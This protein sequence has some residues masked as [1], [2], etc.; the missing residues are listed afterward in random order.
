[1]ASETITPKEHKRQIALYAKERS[2]Y[3]TY[4]TALRRVLQDACSVSIPEAFAQS[5]AK[6][7]SSFAEKVV[8]KYHKYKDPVHELTDLC[9]ARV[10]VQTLEQVQAVREFV[11]ANF[12][13]GEAD[14]K[15]LAL[16]DD[17]FGYRDMHYIVRLNPKNASAIGFTREEIK[18]IG[19]RRAEIQVRTWLQHAWA[20]TLHDRIY[21]NPLKLSTEMKRTGNLLAALM[22]E[23]DRNYNAMAHEIDGMLANYTSFATRDDV[24]KEIEVQQLILSHEPVPAKRPALSLQ[25]GRLLA[26]CG[27]FETVAKVLAPHEKVSGANRCELLQD[28]GLALCK[29]HRNRPNSREYGRGRGLLEAAEALCRETGC[30][31]V[32]HLRKREGLHARALSRLA[33]ALEPLRSEWSAARRYHQQAHEHEPH[34]PYYLADMLG[35][36]IYSGHAKAQ[37]SGMRTALREAVQTCRSHAEAGIERP[38]AW[39]T[40]GRLGLLLGKPL[41]ALG[42]YAR[43]IRHC[44]AGTHCAPP[45]ALAC[46]RDWVERLHVGEEAPAEYRWVLDLLALAERTGADTDVPGAL[47][48]I[49]IIFSGGAESL[50]RKTMEAIRPLIDDVLT[51]F[52]GIVISGGTTSGV[53]GCVGK[54]AANLRRT[55]KQFELNGYIPNKLPHDAVKDKYYDRLVPCGE[56]G[57]SPD[58]IL[59]SWKDLVEKDIA[60]KDV[61]CIGFGGGPI[62]AVEYRVALALGARVVPACRS[63]GTA[64]A[65]IED[66]LWAGVPNLMPL[67]LDRASFHALL[68]SGDDELDPNTVERMAQAFHA[69]Y[70]EESAHRLPGNMRPWETLGCTYQKSNSEQAKYAKLILEACGFIVRPKAQPK[71]RVTFTRK[72]IERMAEMEHGRWNVERIRD[73]WRYGRPRDDNRKLHDCLVSWKELSED[74]KHYDRIA[75]RQFPEVLARAG[76]EVGRPQAQASKKTKRARR[77]KR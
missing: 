8:R 15:G 17:R 14:E 49:A 59:K 57:F 65:L 77:E 37:P 48:P 71:I 26:A 50:D 23:G 36:E 34:N 43:G 13:I 38:R 73:G 62:S 3:V 47:P 33:W 66:M 69:R 64:D 52:A 2:R 40:A 53:P 22:E 76:L 35:F 61:V 58:Q 46:E 55:K 54:T 44:L 39:F 68:R 25:L 19:T 11:E 56:A 7:I 12:D 63:G 51:P 30:P 24:R 16:G 42:D 1:M 70:V 9:G 4:A 74:I 45:D 75:V 28:F 18:A 20:D 21:K 29:V 5:R 31:S 72:E 10:I 6:T 67:P 27:D 41:E 60:P 32:P